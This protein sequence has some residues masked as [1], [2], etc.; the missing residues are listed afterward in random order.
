MLLLLSAYGRSQTGTTDPNLPHIKSVVA[1]CTTKVLIVVLSESVKCSSL[2]ADA[3]EFVVTPLV[4]SYIQS[5]SANSCV[6]STNIDTVWITLSDPLSPGNY[7]V[8]IQNG[9]DGNT[10]VD[11]NGKQIPAGETVGFTI[12]PPIPTP[13]DS[14]SPVACSPGSLQLIFADPISCNSIAADGSDFKIFG[15]P[16]VI[17]SKAEGYCS[18]GFTRRVK[19]TLGS[20]LIKAGNYELFLVRGSD[21]NTIV[22]AV[23]HRNPGGGS[24]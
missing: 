8:T 17:I 15:A 14:L 11:A 2:S 19:I 21:G 23:R 5:T 12:L 20:T 4:G 3:S 7:S 9:T 22:N 18:D 16:S 1:E 13:L 10:L 24:D 6:F